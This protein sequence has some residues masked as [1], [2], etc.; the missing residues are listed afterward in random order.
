[1][2]GRVLGWT[3]GVIAAVV[4]V[5]LVIWLVVPGEIERSGGGGKAS[6]APAATTSATTGNARLDVTLLPGAARVSEVVM[7]TGRLVDTTSGRPIKDVHFDLKSWRLEDDL[8]VFKATVGAVDGTFTWGEQFW[9]GAEHEL[10]I[11]ARP[12][13]GA[14]V[15]SAPVELKSLV[16]VE[17]IAP[18]L[19]V[20]IRATLYLVAV[21]AI[22][23][24]IGIPL[25]GR[26]RGVFARP[27]RRA[28]EPA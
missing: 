26:I 20:Q 10:R 23:L 27:Q 22:G 24:V 18:P 21:A 3:L 13:P 2:I 25:G 8:A 11:T 16:D 9:D 19:W 7:V 28:R 5:A 14:S 4:T 12:A 15:Q 1:M 6:E 17:G